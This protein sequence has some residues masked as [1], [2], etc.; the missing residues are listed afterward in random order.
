MPESIFDRIERLTSSGVTTDSFLVGWLSSAVPEVVS[1]Q[2]DII[3]ARHTRGDLRM[4]TG[5]RTDGAR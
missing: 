1:E 4:V 5:V 2:L 3:E